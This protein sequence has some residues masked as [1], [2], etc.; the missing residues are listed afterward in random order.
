MNKEEIE[1]DFERIKRFLSLSRST[2]LVVHDYH[3]E[4]FYD[5]YSDLVILGIKGGYKRKLLVHE[6]LHATGLEHDPSIGYETW[7]EK[8]E[9]SKLVTRKI[10]AR[11]I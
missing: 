3:I 9:Y 11:K 6:C 4:G 5:R 2:R 1:A 7:M 10:F 8:D